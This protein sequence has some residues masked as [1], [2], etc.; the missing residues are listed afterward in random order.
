MVGELLGQRTA[1]VVRFEGN[2]N[3]TIKVMMEKKNPRM[4][5]PTA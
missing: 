1:S 5:Q 4:S 3:K 2:T